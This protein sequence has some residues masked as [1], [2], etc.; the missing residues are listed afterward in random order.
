MFSATTGACLRAAAAVFAFGA[1]IT[2][3]SDQTLS[4]VLWRS[5]AWSTS[6]QPAASAR[7]ETRTKSGAVCGGQTC[8]MSNSISTS[9]RA[10]PGVLTSR[11]AR[12]AGPSTAMRSWKK[13]SVAP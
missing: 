8:S 1:F 13:S 9:R 3:P 10:S 11:T 12:R 4:W 6:T 5:V 2:S 7:G